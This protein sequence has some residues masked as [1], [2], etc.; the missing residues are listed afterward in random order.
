MVHESDDEDQVRD[1]R[2]GSERCLHLRYV[3][4]FWIGFRCGE[5]KKKMTLWLGG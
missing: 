1:V 3:Y 5:G 4:S 2:A